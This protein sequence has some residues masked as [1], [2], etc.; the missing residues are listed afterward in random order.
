MKISRQVLK[1]E[2][3]ERSQLIRNDYILRINKYSANQLVFL[4]KRAANEH[5][6]YR[7]FLWSV[8]GISPKAIRPVKRSERWR[9]LLTYSPNGVLATHIYQGGLTAARFEGFLK[10]KCFLNTVAPIQ[11]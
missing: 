8:Y 1:K 3:M 7:K 5:I 10:T 6:L 4:D 9:I 2:A 11:F